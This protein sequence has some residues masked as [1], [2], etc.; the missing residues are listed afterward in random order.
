MITHLIHCHLLHFG[1]MTL[2]AWK[3][4]F[5]STCSLQ[6]PK[7]KIEMKGSFSPMERSAAIAEHLKRVE[8]K[9]EVVDERVL[10]VLKFLCAFSIRFSF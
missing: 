10:E 4:M 3:K 8:V 1:M 5:F 9:C 7:H 2:L 6:G